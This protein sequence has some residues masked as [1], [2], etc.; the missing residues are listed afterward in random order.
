M[1]L[2]ALYFGIAGAGA[3]LLSVFKTVAKG[4]GFILRTLPSTPLQWGIT[5][6][7]GAFFCLAAAVLLTLKNK[8]GRQARSSPKVPEIL[9][10]HD[11]GG[12]QV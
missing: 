3:S 6:V 1:M 7:I 12:D 10:A 11:G 8:N 4:T 9:S 5:A 2:A